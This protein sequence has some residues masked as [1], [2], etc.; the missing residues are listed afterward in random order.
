MV[1]M[2]KS[3]KDFELF[4]SLNPGTVKVFTE[5]SKDAVYSDP[6]LPHIG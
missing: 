2:A 6:H 4:G 3:A 5:Q 1:Q